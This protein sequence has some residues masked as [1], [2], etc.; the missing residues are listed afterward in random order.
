MKKKIVIA[1][2]SGF[3]GRW[4]IKKFKNEYDIIALSRK[5]VSNNQDKNIKWKKVDLYSITSTEKALEGCDVAIYLVHSMQPSSRLNQSKFEDTDLLLADNFSRAAEKNK[6][7]QIIYVGGILPKDKI[8]ISKH[9]LSRYE[10]EKTLSSRSTPL[11]SI[12]AGIIIGP[13][14]SS[15]KIITNLV[16]NLPVMMCPLWTKSI[17]Q[18]LDVFDLLNIL[19]ICLSDQK[20]YNKRIEIGGGEII[21][22][23]N[24]LKRTALLMKKRRIIFSIPLFSLGLSKL[25]VSLFT[26]TSLNLISPLVESLKHKM[27]PDKENQNLFNINFRKLDDSIVKALKLEAPKLPRFNKIKFEKNTVRSVQRIYNP[28]KYSAE[29][30]ADYFPVWISKK[31]VNIINPKFDGNNLIFYLG[32]INLLK[33]ELIRNRSS[34]DRKLFYITGGV[35]TKRKNLGWLEFRSILNNNY[36]MIAIHEFIPKLPWMIYKNS[37]AKIHLYVM[38]KFEKEIMKK[39]IIKSELNET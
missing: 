36:I 10:V 7:K 18:P 12:G 25:W 9:L 15:F 26:N 13:G 3:I 31:F 37:Q 20:T 19:R 6:L 29:K 16:K 24:L 28:N 4:I 21:T 23:M 2:A 30:V 34:R 17:N 14:G 39:N 27:V 1:G 38:K 11:T 33:L 8:K 5:E 35:L 22:Y 32:K